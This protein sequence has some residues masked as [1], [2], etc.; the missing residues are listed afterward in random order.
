VPRSVSIKTLE[1]NLAETGPALEVAKK[2]HEAALYALKAEKERLLT[3]RALQIGR[4]AQSCGL[5]ELEDG[6]LESFFKTY[7]RADAV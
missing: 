2:A 5:G 1:D 4:L 6:L 7:R 3:N